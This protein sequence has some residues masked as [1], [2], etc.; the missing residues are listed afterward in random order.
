MSAS[1]TV[2]G[3]LTRRLRI[4]AA[5]T[6]LV[7]WSL[8]AAAPPSYQRTYPD[9]ASRQVVIDMADSSPA[10]AV[11]MGRLPAPGNLGQFNGSD[12]KSVV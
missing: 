12:R 8:V 9:A 4:P 10:V 3:L 1:R 2:L 5:V 11:L 6:L 7:L